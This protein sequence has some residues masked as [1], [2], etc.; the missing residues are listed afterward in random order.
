MRSGHGVSKLMLPGPGPC[1]GFAPQLLLTNPEFA[2]FSYHRTTKTNA[3]RFMHQS[4]CNPPYLVA[5]RSNQRGLLE[6][7]P[8]LTAKIIAR[9]LSPSPATLKAHMKRPRKGMRS[10]TPKQMQPAQ[11][12]LP[13]PP[14]AQSI[15]G[16][17]MFGLIPDNEDNKLMPGLIPDDKD[18]KK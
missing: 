13:H 2:M 14:S 6:G 11:P 4:L 7:A 5:H 10:T 17:L 3:V 15:H 18:S 12:A 9:Y 1:K 16:Q 8:H